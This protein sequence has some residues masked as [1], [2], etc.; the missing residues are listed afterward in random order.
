M[1]NGMTYGMSHHYY[2][3]ILTFGILRQA[4]KVFYE[5][6]WEMEVAIVRIVGFEFKN[7]ACIWKAPQSKLRT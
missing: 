7:R 1:L 5:L 4:G 3:M 2:P 6:R